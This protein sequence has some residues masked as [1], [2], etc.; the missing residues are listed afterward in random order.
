MGRRFHDQP[1]AVH[2]P[3]RLG[4]GSPSTP[5]KLVLMRLFVVCCCCY[6]CCC[7][8]PSD[9]SVLSVP[10]FGI[11]GVR[12][13]CKTPVC[14]RRTTSHDVT[15]QSEFS[16]GSSLTKHVAAQVLL[17][18]KGRSTEH[19]NGMYEGVAFADSW[20]ATYRRLTPD[21][22][23]DLPPECEVSSMIGMGWV[24]VSE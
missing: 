10:C 7:W 3:K 12:H 16:L 13:T 6:F 14:V 5:S 22:P 8:L 23:L 18:Y 1:C 17:V 2:L 20:N 9:P 11:M 4:K 15:K 24:F 19:P 21:A